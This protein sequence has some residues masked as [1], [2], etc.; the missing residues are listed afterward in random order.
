MRFEF[1]TTRFVLSPRESVESPVQR[2]CTHNWNSKA[3]GGIFFPL[4]LVCGLAIWLTFLPPL[5][6]GKSLIQHPQR[7][8]HCLQD[9]AQWVNATIITEITARPFAS[10][11]FLKFSHSLLFKEDILVPTL[12]S[13]KQT[14]TVYIALHRSHNSRK[15][16]QWQD[17]PAFQP[18]GSTP[19]FSA[20]CSWTP[21]TRN[22]SE[23]S[24]T[25]ISSVGLKSLAR[26]LLWKGF[27]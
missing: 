11:D 10:I 14:Q 16:L 12:L 24:F 27:W 5:G 17:G 6:R 4:I 2:K 7:G 23:R 13:G 25:W 18:K 3:V 8:P 20:L 19:Q 22:L 9:K 26:S 1:H 15:V 21:L